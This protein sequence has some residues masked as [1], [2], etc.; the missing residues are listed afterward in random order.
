VTENT[1]NSGSEITIGFDSNWKDSKDVLQCACTSDTCI[2]REW[3][4]N[5]QVKAAS[6]LADMKAISLRDSDSEEEVKKKKRGRKPKSE[7]MA[8]LAAQQAAQS[9]SLEKKEGSE[10]PVPLEKMSREE[11]K[12]ALLMKSFQKME[13]RQHR[14]RKH[15]DGESR[16]GRKP[17][18][19]RKRV[20]HDEDWQDEDSESDVDKESPEP[21]E[22]KPKPKAKIPRKDKDDKQEA[23]SE[24]EPTTVSAP[25]TLPVE[26]KE[27]AKEATDIEPMPPKQEQV[28]EKRESEKI[29]MDRMESEKRG[30]EKQ[31]EKKE[32]EPERESVTTQPTPPTPASPGRSSHKFGKKAWIRDYQEHIKEEPKV[33]ATK[34]DEQYSAEPIK[35]EPAKEE[36]KSQ[37]PKTTSPKEEQ[38]VSKFPVKKKMLGSFLTDQDSQSKMDTRIDERNTPS[39]RNNTSP[40]RLD[41]AKKD[42]YGAPTSPSKNHLSERKSPESNDRTS[43]RDDTTPSFAKH[44]PSPRN[45]GPYPP[46]AQNMGYPVAP[47]QRYGTQ[48]GGQY[49][50]HP[51]MHQPPVYGDNPAHYYYPRPEDYR[52]DEYRRK[53]DQGQPSFHPTRSTTTEAD[54]DMDIDEENVQNNIL[55]VSPQASA[56]YPNVQTVTT[57]AVTPPSHHYSSQRYPPTQPAPYYNNAIPPPNAYPNPPLPYQQSSQYPP[58]S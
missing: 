47:Q 6:A 40:H 25:E 7:T 37:E 54:H 20:T 39:P 13:N 1:L 57:P 56:Q 41:E 27:Q 49:P 29:D 14:K 17:M 4:K 48:Y 32:P 55:F 38:V 10:A 18:L 16:R 34:N 26:R 21:E 58:R 22:E 19:R 2:V 33:E 12:I 45:S 43:N 3:F 24:P 51:Y 23:K 8:A 11:R 28:M 50:P 36:T 9:P 5:R 44:S 46:Y 30:L 15:Y 53:D 35:I 52:S 31:T 42:I